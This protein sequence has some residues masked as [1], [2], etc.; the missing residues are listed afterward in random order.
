M[1]DR[2]GYGPARRGRAGAAGRR[3]RARV[4][5]VE[6]ATAVKKT[7]PVRI[8]ALGTVTP[9]ASVAIKTRIDS[10]IIAVHFADGALVKQGDLL[11]TLDSRAI[12]A[13]ILQAEGDASRRDK[14]Q[15]E[16]AERD[17]AP[18]HRAGREE[19]H[20]G[21][22]SRQ[23]Q[24]PGRR[25]VRAA[26]KSNEA[27]LEEP[28]GAAELHDDPRADLRPHQRGGR[29]GRQLRAPGRSAAARDHHP[30]RADL[31]HVPGAA[32]TLPELREAIADGTRD[33]R[34]DRSRARASAPA[35]RVTM[36][37]NTVDAAT[38]MVTVRATM[39]NEDELLWPGTLVHAR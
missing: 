16:Q 8:D 3:R 29:Q 33:D 18:L 5:P 21:H 19:R 35:G 24:D 25:S 31:R 37:E 39:P 34:G 32:G 38:G 9:M 22:Q 1:A 4:V 36:I 10:E 28:A 23:R 14:A 17:V 13:Q 11:F 26:L 12:E 15:L 30:D 2:D 20:P 7:V 27:M 6:V